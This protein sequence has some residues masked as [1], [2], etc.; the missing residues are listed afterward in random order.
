MT[1]RKM[2][3]T[4]KTLNYLERRK[5]EI[6]KEKAST[7]RGELELRFVLKAISTEIN[8]L[9]RGLSKAVTI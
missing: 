7:P 5:A 9:Q 4:I 2:E 6:A 3:K 1:E 8:R